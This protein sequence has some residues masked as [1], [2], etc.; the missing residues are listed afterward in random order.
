MVTVL[1]SMCLLITPG[2]SYFKK[3][4][5]DEGQ[6][7]EEL[8]Q[9]AKD[10]MLKKNWETAIERLRTVEARYPYGV[11][12]EQAQLDTVYV[13]YRSEQT[14][15]ALAAADRFI[16]LHPTHPSVDYAH[17]LKGLASFSEN[18]SLLGKLMGHDD[19]SD[20]DATAIRNAK[21]AFEEVYTLFPDS[22]YAPDSKK[23][24]KYLLSSLAKNEI[25]IANYYYS[26]EA[27][28]AVVNR[29][30]GI[31][32]NYSSTPSV[33]EALALMMFSYHK[34]GFDDLSSD[35]RRVL[36]LNFPNS[37]YLTMDPSKVKISNKDGVEVSGRGNDQGWFSSIIGRFKKD[38]DSG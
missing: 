17:Y 10:S 28:V 18:K 22:Q 26:R 1:L 36:E 9:D 11:Y 33:E 32:E 13:Y 20:R 6:T 4:K 19:L 3:D 30:K 15:L 5:S 23:R 8:Y 27:Y 25:T 7:A 29:A 21:A 37:A 16:K 2:C 14:G 12:A 24:A 38:D 34:M 31:I 35:S